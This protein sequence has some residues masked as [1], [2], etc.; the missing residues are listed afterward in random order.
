MVNNFRKF[1]V[2]YSTYCKEENYGIY[3]DI[4]KEILKSIKNA[5]NEDG[6]EHHFSVCESNDCQLFFINIDNNYK[7]CAFIYDYELFESEPVINIE[8]LMKEYD[9]TDK[10]LQGIYNSEPSLLTVPEPQIYNYKCQV[11]LSILD[12]VPDKW[13]LANKILAEISL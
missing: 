4:T 6:L 8:K 9:I 12:A 1:D 10:E 13:A 5:V 3:L 11:R 7:F 2:N